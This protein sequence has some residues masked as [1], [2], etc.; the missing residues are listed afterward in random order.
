VIAVGRIPLEG[1]LRRHSHGFG[2]RFRLD[3]SLLM[4]VD[5]G[6]VFRLRRLR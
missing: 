2:N 1:N 3:G 6:A 5:R 4:E